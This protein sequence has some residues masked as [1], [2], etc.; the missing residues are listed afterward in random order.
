MITFSRP[1][2]RFLFHYGKRQNNRDVNAPEG[3]GMK[4]YR[5]ADF[6]PEFSC[7]TLCVSNNAR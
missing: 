4:F 7:K 5:E 1:H 6:R 3:A 2:L